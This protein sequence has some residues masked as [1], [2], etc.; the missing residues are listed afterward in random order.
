ML[1]NNLTIPKQVFFTAHKNAESI[2]QYSIFSILETQI[3]PHLLKADRIRKRHLTLVP[4][5]RALPS[6][7]ELE[8]FVNLCISQDQKVS[9][10]FV[11]HFLEKGLNKEDI[12]LE[13]IAPA[14]RYLG[15]QWDDDRMDFSQVNLGLVRLHTIANE[16]RFAHTD[17]QFGLLPVSQTPT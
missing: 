10:A 17:S 9:Q 7:N 15:S 16:I 1:S 14:A 5:S 11:D 8:I 12:F 2:D 3:I 13:L 4:S 6:Q